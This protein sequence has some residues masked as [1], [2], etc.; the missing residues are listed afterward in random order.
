MHMTDL[1]LNS[2]SKPNNLEFFLF[3]CCI[4]DSLMQSL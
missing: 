3:Y 2:S 4:V 1:S